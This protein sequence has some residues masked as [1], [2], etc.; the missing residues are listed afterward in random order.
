[1]FKI[2][3]RLKREAP[4]F[5]GQSIWEKELKVRLFYCKKF[6]S[7][8]IMFFYLFKEHF[9]LELQRNEFF[10]TSIV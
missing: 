2:I 3:S 4:M 9:K 5:Y 1:L 8:L 6:F 7:V 10:T